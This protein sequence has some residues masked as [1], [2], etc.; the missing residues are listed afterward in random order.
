[1]RMLHAL[2]AELGT[3]AFFDL[4]RRYADAG[5]GRVVDDDVFWSMLT[6]EQSALVDRVRSQYFG[7]P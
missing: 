2:R 6:P 1:A 3:D 4:L 5:T 7:S